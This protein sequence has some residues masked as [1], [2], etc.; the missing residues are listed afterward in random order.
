MF[1]D[2]NKPKSSTVPLLLLASIFTCGLTVSNAKA[3]EV[4][5]SGF[6]NL[7]LTYAEHDKLA[8]R[9][10]LQKNGREGLS[11]APDSILGL[12]SNIEFNDKFD[13]VGQIIL[14][15]RDNT[16]FANYIEL[17][18]LRYQIDRHWSAKIGRFSTNSYLYTDYR[19]VGHLLNWVRPP[20]EMYS[21]AGALGSMDGLQASYIQDADFGAV[22][23]ALSYGQSNFID[24]VEGGELT[25]DY[26]ELA[27][28]NIELQSTDWRFH[29]AFIRSTLDNFDTVGIDDVKN[30]EGNVPP[31]FSPFARELVGNIVP[32]GKVITY[33]SVGGQ[34]NVDSLELNAELFDY[35][36]DWVLAGGSVGGYIS[37]AY[38]LGN[39]KPYLTLAT[40]NRRLAPEVI[41]YERAESLLPPVAF[42]QLVILS[43]ESNEAVRGASYDQKSISAGVRWDFHEAWSFKVQFDHFRTSEFGSGL[44]GVQ[45]GL[46]TPKEELS[47]NVLSLS[48]TTIF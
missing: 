34:Y 7:S 26:S 18:F 15:D 3:T 33:A 4:S 17:A 9:S 19:N 16:Q 44:F 27:V 10:S 14:Q 46:L 11:F 31:L 25:I 23:V 21:T 39:V 42:Q 40:H 37:A 5:F 43:A 13:A 38:Q 48:F 35:D 2:L 30:L 29:A 28:L 45:A 20:V 41:D 36:S 8:Y 47:L 6:T 32:D 1:I 12:Q 24:D 22:K